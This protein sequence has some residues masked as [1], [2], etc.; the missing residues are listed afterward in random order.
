MAAVSGSLDHYLVETGHVNA[1]SI[2]SN[3]GNVPRKLF[4]K[5]GPF[6]K[7]IK[8]FIEHKRLSGRKYINVEYYLNA[9]NLFCAMNKDNFSLPQQFAETWCNSIG[10]KVC[11]DI[12]AI[13]EFGLHLTLKDSKNAFLIPYAN[14]DM[15]KPAFAGYTCLFAEEIDSFLK[16]KRSDGFKYRQEEF[17]LKDF[18]RFCNEHSALPAQQLADAFINSC[19]ETGY[20]MGIRSVS[21]IRAFGNYLTENDSPNAFSIVDKYFVAGPYAE[22]IVVFVAFKRSSGF[23]Y[24]NSAYHVRCFDAFCTLA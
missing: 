8:D 17:R 2:L 21:V 4:I 20:Y 19:E 6:E 10:K 9:F 16:A 11:A 13:R 1:F 18:D 7:D 5:I 14:G 15:P 3:K 22:E 24:P 23:K 12:S